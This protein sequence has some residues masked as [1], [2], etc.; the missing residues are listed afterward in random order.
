MSDKLNHSDLSALFAK[1][2]NISLAKAELFTKAM[3]DLIIEG[4]EQDGIVKINGL[5]TFKIADV[6]SRSSV[7]VNTGEKFEIKGHRKLVFI[8][9][10]TLKDDVN[11]P[12]SMFEPVEVDESY[13]EDE[14]EECG[15]VLSDS[16]LEREA[17]RTAAMEIE[18]EIPVESDVHAPVRAENENIEEEMPVIDEVTANPSMGTVN[19]NVS[20][21]C[22]SQDDS[23]LADEDTYE[24]QEEDIEEVVEEE[25][26][27]E[28]TLSIIPEN[29]PD[30]KTRPVASVETLED[31]AACIDGHAVQESPSTGNVTLENHIKENIAA[32]SSPVKKGVSRRGVF[33]FFL[34][35]VLVL[36]IGG[37]CLWNSDSCIQEPVM[38]NVAEKDTKTKIV[39]AVEEPASV[40]DNNPIVAEPVKEEPYRFIA[41]EKFLSLDIA[42][43]SV[44]DTVLYRAT[45]ELARHK[46]QSGDRLTKISLEYYGDKRLWPYIVSYNRLDDPNG[47]AEG[48]ELS[49][50]MLRPVE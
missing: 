1:D 39:V 22:N 14:S 42:K 26:I 43:V 44:A 5:G 36:I 29:G 25:N 2:T 33:V 9:A 46:V 10:D 11:Q 19:K 17:A 16:E 49:I 3:F 24:Y 12:F 7:N 48:M 8:P 47:I 4:L 35:S 40:A 13:S 23:Y 28:E 45:G 50:P 34:I 41:T 37:Y 20:A 15:T 38:S 6:A 32:A 18:E 27:V 30:E 31:D 21:D